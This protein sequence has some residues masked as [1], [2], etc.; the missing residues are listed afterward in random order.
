MEKSLY[1]IVRKAEENLTSR[2]VKLGEYVNWNLH[3]TTETIFAYLNSKHI[4]GDKDALHRDKP[5]FNIV[6]AAVNIWYRATDLDRKD[7]IIKADKESNTVAAFLATIKLQEWMK[8]SKFGVFLNSW[9]RTLA[10]YG[11]AVVK[12]VEKDGELVASVIPWN[13]LIVDQI[14]FYALPRIE[15]FYK[16]PAQL[17]NMATPGHPDYIGLYKDKVKGLLDGKQSRKTIDDDQKD[18]M[19]EFIELYE[20]HG[21]LSLAT[22]KDAKGETVNEGDEDIYF[23]QM[24]IMT[25]FKNK[26]GKYENFTLYS[27]KEKQDPYMITH[28]I[29]E[30]GRTLAIGAVEYLFDSQWM[31]NHTMK[32]WKDQMDLSSKIIFQTSDPKFVGKNVLTNIEVG[33]I[34]IHG[35]NAPLSQV[36]NQGHDITSLKDFKDQWQ[37]LN[38]EITSTPDAVRGNTLP[39]GTP[40][41]LG[42]Y[43]GTQSLSLFEI[44]VENKGL[45]LEEMLR[46]YIIPH[47]KT[48]LNDNKE[49]MATLEDAGIK[50]IDSIFVPKEAIKRFNK[51]DKEM[52]IS[53]EVPPS[54]NEVKGEIEGQIRQ[55]LGTLGN[56]RSIE[57]GQITWKEVLDDLEW[58]V[59]VGIT[60]EQADK[61]AILTT[62]STVLQTIAQ[63]PLI[64]QDENA[65]MLFNKILSY[66]GTVSPVE[67]SASSTT[68][69]PP[70]PSQS[71]KG[72]EQLATTNQP[73]Q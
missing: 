44:M 67:L 16:T 25:W 2:T 7:M 4:S 20:V 37:V 51:K 8:K 45:A 14:D 3:E 31:Q 69:Q 11:S 22:Y 21:E 49:I 18:T 33:D 40:Y 13:R 70:Q 71:N 15:K 19:D 10:Q 55:E 72:L 29:E 57:P 26:D 23:Q 9:G 46:K 36:N 28:L 12:F 41:S 56:N 27:G 63:N 24:H 34:F 64:L 32:A 30:D 43:L 53:G 58:K 65:K 68:S 38:Q 42:A 61:Q 50:Q 6:T 66:T 60:N 5:F 62:L 54:F 47:L 48:K 52:L 59:D 17:L 35:V 39:S 1:E 73:N